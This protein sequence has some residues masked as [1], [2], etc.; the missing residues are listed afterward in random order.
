MDVSVAENCDEKVTVKQEIWE[1]DDFYCIFANEDFTYDY[2]IKDKNGKELL[3]V[4]G[5]PKCPSINRVSDDVL[6]L[7]I[8]TGTGKATAIVRYFNTET[9]EVSTPFSYVLGEVENKVIYVDFDAN[10]GYSVVMCNIFDVTDIDCIATLED[11][12]TVEPIVEY[13]ISNE[14]IYIVYLKGKDYVETEI[15]ITPEKTPGVSESFGQTK[16]IAQELLAEIESAYEYE[17]DRVFE[18]R[19]IDAVVFKY[20]EKW[21]A[22]AE[23]YCEKTKALGDGR[24]KEDIENIKENGEKYIEAELENYNSILANIFGMGTIRGS[25]YLGHEYQLYKAWALRIV[26]IYLTAE[27]PYM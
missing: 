2:Y 8:Q 11:V 3:S 12:H 23:E 14:Q 27:I 16:N 25:F 5:D 1:E 22:V 21:K 13:V 18:I 9:G 15:R 10:R 7:G 4:K 24:Y 20:T 6:S 17:L 26:D 19:D